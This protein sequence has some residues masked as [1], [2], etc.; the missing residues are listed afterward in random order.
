MLKTVR[1]NL[2]TKPQEKQIEREKFAEFKER[3]RDKILR[4]P[5]WTCEN[6]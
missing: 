2:R 5:I 6:E 4:F 3:V 1:E